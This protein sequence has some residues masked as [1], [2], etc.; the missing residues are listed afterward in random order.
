MN[1]FLLKILQEYCNKSIV[2]IHNC[3]YFNVM[4][5]QQELN[6]YYKITPLNLPSDYYIYR[7][8]QQIEFCILPESV[9]LYGSHDKQRI[10]S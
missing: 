4:F 8:L 6:L 10:I 7:L 5:T 3:K 9:F 2:L 1:Y